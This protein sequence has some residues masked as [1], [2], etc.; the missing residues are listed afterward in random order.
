MTSHC[1]RTTFCKM[2][3]ADDNIRWF[4]HHCSS[5]YNW[6]ETSVPMV[7][8]ATFTIKHIKRLVI[9][10]VSKKVSS[11]FF[12]IILEYSK[13]NGNRVAFYIEPITAHL[14]DLIDDDGFNVDNFMTY[15][16]SMPMVVPEQ[17]SPLANFLEQDTPLTNNLSEHAKKV[18]SRQ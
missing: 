10:H 14:L 11:D 12:R 17:S 5:T 1:T 4:H 2:T 15:H 9:S 6:L 8:M 16:L 18:L 13:A 7:D 3:N